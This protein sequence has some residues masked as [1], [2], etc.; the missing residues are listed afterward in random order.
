VLLTKCHSGDKI[1]ANNVGGACGR[2][3]TEYNCTQHFGSE[4]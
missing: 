4:T 3:G 1:L 2:Y